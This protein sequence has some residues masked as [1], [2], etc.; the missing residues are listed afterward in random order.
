VWLILPSAWLLVG[1]VR[2]QVKPAYLAAVMLGILLVLAKDYGVPGLTKL[3]LW[4]NVLL[5][6][7]LV[8]GL[9]KKDLLPQ[10]PGTSQ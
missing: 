2:Q 3:N 9:L 4:G 7:M 6:A 10:T 8:I 1:L 5:S